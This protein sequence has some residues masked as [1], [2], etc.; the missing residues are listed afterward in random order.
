MLV[1]LGVLVANMVCHTILCQNEPS[2]SAVTLDSTP[3]DPS[4]KFP[5]LLQRRTTS[6]LAVEKVAVAATP[7]KTAAS[8]NPSKTLGFTHAAHGKR[9][10]AI[11]T[12]AFLELTRDLSTLFDHQAQAWYAYAYSSFTEANP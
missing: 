7:I 11:I 4:R 3:G 6:D 8:K 2:T 9:K 12:E 10:C 1:K 5:K